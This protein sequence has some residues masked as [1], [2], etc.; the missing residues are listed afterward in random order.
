MKKMNLSNIYEWP[1]ITK[2]LLFGL[3]FILAFYLGYWFDLSGQVQNLSH[4]KQQEDDLMQQ[5]ELVIR[6]D[7]LIQADVAR[8]PGLQTEL[9]KWKK[10]LVSFKELPELLNMV[11][12]LGGDNHL[13][14]SLFSPGEPENV[15]LTADSTPANPPDQAAVVPEQNAKKI[16]Y[17]KVPIKVVVVGNY[18]QIASFISEVANMAWVVAIRNF[19]ISNENETALLGAKL[20]KQ[21]EAQR[22]LS[23]ELMLDV[24]HL[25]ESK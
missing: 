9:I 1:L 14:F 25:P 24:Y 17:V 19:T 3:V 11:L 8:L 12:K 21:A 16:I 13:F 6:K 7:K 22:L 4:A 10:Q 2:L 23:A 15:T 20:A 18:H 5:I